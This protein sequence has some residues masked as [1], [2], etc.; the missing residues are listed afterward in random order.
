MLYKDEDRKGDRHCRDRNGC[1][2][3]RG[4]ICVAY[5][6]RLL[7]AN[8][9]SGRRRC[10]G[11]FRLLAR[12]GRRIRY[13]RVV[14]DLDGSSRLTVGSEQIAHKHPAGKILVAVV[15]HC[16]MPP[17]HI[18]HIANAIFDLQLGIVFDE[19][20][21]AVYIAF[22][23][24]PRDNISIFVIRRINCPVFYEI[25]RIV[26]WV[27]YGLYP[28]LG[29]CRNRQCSHHEQQHQGEEKL[30]FHTNASNVHKHPKYSTYARKMKAQ[31]C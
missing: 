22:R 1:V 4:I 18:A 6:Y 12:F 11:V 24:F 31:F 30:F 13:H 29:A 16:D 10:L 3:Y 27:G 2:H 9:D 19:H 5:V 8:R 21:L 17:R 28:Q 23:R 7:R 26:P 15:F 25:I 14:G 20:I